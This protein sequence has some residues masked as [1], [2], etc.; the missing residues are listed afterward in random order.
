MKLCGLLDLVCIIPHDSI[1]LILQVK[2]SEGKAGR[3]DVCAI[4]FMYALA[5][6]PPLSMPS[7]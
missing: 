3:L 7:S 6:W 2:S 1:E 5:E 4:L